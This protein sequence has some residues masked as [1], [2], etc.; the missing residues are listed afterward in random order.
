M[1]HTP[2][3]NGQ[4]FQRS[5]LLW[6]GYLENLLSGFLSVGLQNVQKNSTERSEEPRVPPGVGLS[7]G[8]LGPQ[9]PQP[10]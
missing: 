10:F 9:R 1:E 5:G 2:H 6:G 3:V 4:H 7:W 8:S